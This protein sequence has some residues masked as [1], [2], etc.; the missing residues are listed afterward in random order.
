MFT[1]ERSVGRHPRA[2]MGALGGA[3]KSHGAGGES[4]NFT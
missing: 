1:D 3:T 4:S 2:G